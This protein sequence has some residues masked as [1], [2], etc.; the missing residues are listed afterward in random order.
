MQTGACRSR[1]YYSFVAYDGALWAT[2][3]PVNSPSAGTV[4]NQLATNSSGDGVNYKLDLTQGGNLTG[5]A[6]VGPMLVSQPPPTDII[7]DAELAIVTTDTAGNVSS[8]GLAA[9]DL[10]NGWQDPSAGDIRYSMMT[11]TARDSS[12]AGSLTYVTPSDPS[13]IASVEGVYLSVDSA[14]RPTGTNYYAL[15]VDTGGT[16]ITGIDTAGSYYSQDQTGLTIVPQNAAQIA[17]VTG[18]YNLNLSGGTVGTEDYLT[19]TSQSFITTLAGESAGLDPFGR[20]ELPLLAVSPTGQAITP[21]NPYITY[22]RTGF[23]PG[24]STIWLTTSLPSGAANGTV[25]IKYSDMRFLH[26]IEGELC[27]GTTYD[28]GEIVVDT[29]TQSG[30]VDSTG[31]IVIP[32]DR[33]SIATVLGVFASDDTT[34]TNYL[35]NPPATPDIDGDLHVATMTGSTAYIWYETSWS[36]FLPNGWLAW[37]TGTGNPGD[38]GL[39]A[40][41]DSSGNSDLTG[42]VVGVWLTPDQTGTNYFDPRRLNGPYAPLDASDSW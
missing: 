9:D 32:S 6:I 33:A 3:D 30:T 12:G 19:G 4:V 37:Y 10:R 16:P 36:Y 27:H 1:Y 23:N 39:K 11:G 31:T 29:A 22:N 34:G 40:D 26:G 38:M 5:A 14:G 15:P 20:I 17:W 7:T 21:P 18:V 35:I 41:V 13:V 28:Y 2:Y 8:Q 42:A 24:D 25:Y